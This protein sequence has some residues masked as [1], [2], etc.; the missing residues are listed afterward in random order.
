MINFFSVCKFNKI[1]YIPQNINQINKFYKNSSYS[2]V[3]PGNEFDRI[4]NYFLKNLCDVNIINE[5]NYISFDLF[6]FY[7]LKFFKDEQITNIVPEKRFKLMMGW[8]YQQV[9]KIT[10]VLQNPKSNNVMIDADTILLR[11]IN[12]FE[13]GK[14]ILHKSSYEKNKNYKLACQEIFSYT[15]K[16]WDSYTVQS[17]SITKEEVEFLYENFKNFIPKDE[18]DSI[19]IWITKIIATVVAKFNNNFFDSYFSEQDIIA[20]S[21]LLIGCKKNNELKFLRSMV[22]GELNPWMLK[23]ASK[24]GFS[25]VTYEHHILKK[26]KANF[27]DFILMSIINFPIIHGFLKRVQRLRKIL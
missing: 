1:D 8:Y 9:L 10:H 2:I 14:S 18:D 20:N 16:N 21:N 19:G 7:F 4:N 24:L 6:K 13:N 25:Y 23:I 22:V 5:E 15:P 26:K 12:F 27:A 17:F 3:S 11:K